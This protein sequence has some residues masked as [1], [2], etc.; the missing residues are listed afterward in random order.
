LSNQKFMKNIYLLIAIML[1]IKPAD[2]Q[3]SITGSTLTY[4]QNFNTLINNGTN[5]TT[6]P[7]GWSIYKP[8][9]TANYNASNGTSNTATVYSYG[10]TGTNERA[11]GSLASGTTPTLYYGARFQN[12]TAVPITGMNITF[13]QEQ[14]RIGDTVV[15]NIDSVQFFY[16]ADANGVNDTSSAVTWVQVPALM[17]TSLATVGSGTVN[18]DSLAMIKTAVLTSLN[19]PNGDTIV[20]RWKDW[21]SASSDDGLAVDSLTIDFYAPGAP[22]NY[23]PL[24][25][26]RFPADNANN[27]PVNTTLRM[28]FDRKVSKGS[29]SIHL[30]NVT[31]QTILSIPANSAAVVLNNGSAGDTVLITALLNYGKA[32]YVLVDSAAF[33]TLG[34][35]Y[36]GIYDTT[37]W[38]FSTPPVPP[39]V[40]NETFDSC[41]FT[42][43]TGWTRFTV[44]GN[45]QQWGCTTNGNNTTNGIAMNGRSATTNNPIP[46]EDWLVSPR[47]DFTAMPLAYLHFDEW[48]RYTSV[49][50][51]QVMVSTNYTG[52]GSPN[53]ATWANLNVPMAATDTGIWKGYEASLNPYKAQL[54]HIAF[55]YVSDTANAYQVRLDNVLVDGL[56][57]DVTGFSKADLSFKVL[58]FA[59]ADAINLAHSFSESGNYKIQVADLA[60]RLVCDRSAYLAS[61]NHT[62]SIANLN[63][64]SGMYIVRISRGN[65]FG[66][67]KAI[68]Q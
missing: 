62:T 28:N 5:L 65:K 25:L 66:V 26:G 44:V 13:K 7:A 21:N 32:Y 2:A 35:K 29:G 50:E 3:I 27:V 53:L 11:L 31:D 61:G 52:S 55:K 46:N 6:M 48:K 41:N 1:C 54:L 45:G 63:L 14:W 56:S 23:K 51:L 39:T 15:A 17:M 67:A 10:A 42:L 68:A 38:N 59:G 34:Y 64:G 16:S 19:I 12:N 9:M 22:P 8:G 30:R 58:G 40:L 20:I 36:N 4:T 33:D 24:L 60:G 43:P 57:L 37:S 18:G 47:V 49:Y